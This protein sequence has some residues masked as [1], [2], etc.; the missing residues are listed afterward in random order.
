M[1]GNWAGHGAGEGSGRKG[2]GGGVCGGKI[3]H[4]AAVQRGGGRGLKKER[5]GWVVGRHKL[6]WVGDGERVWLARGGKKGV[7]GQRLGKRNGGRGG[8]VQGVEELSAGVWEGEK[9]GGWAMGWGGVDKRGGCSR[10]G[11]GCGGGGKG[12]VRGEKWSG[13]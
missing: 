8:R 9:M 3:G 5:T 7:G 2:V 10:R 1:W 13:G 4:T 6:V 12:W 11:V